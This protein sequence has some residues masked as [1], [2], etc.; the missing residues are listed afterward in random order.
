[1]DAVAHDTDV[2]TAYVGISGVLHPSESLY[3]LLCRR[4]PWS[5]GHTKYE[6]VPVLVN[7]LKDWPDVRIV[8]TSTQPRAHG[9]GSVLEHLGPALAARVVGYTYEDLTIKAQRQVVTRSST[10]RTL[11]FSNEDYWRMNKSDIVAA[12]V[13]WRRPSRWVVIDDED[14]LWPHE[15]RRDRLVL[16]DGCV[17]L[18]SAETQDRLHTVLQMNFGH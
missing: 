2:P 6:G 4:S 17:G 13:A 14:I 18:L 3:E 7:A 16:T 8:L 15:V 1:M 11:G 9:L 5:D 10:T 12:H